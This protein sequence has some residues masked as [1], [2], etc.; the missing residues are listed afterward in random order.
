MSGKVN[1]CW[2]SLVRRDHGVSILLMLLATMN[3]YVF[4]F[5]VARKIKKHEKL[6]KRKLQHPKMTLDGIVLLADNLK[7]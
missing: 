7:L 3:R 5:S 2:C 1:M 6:K 4:F